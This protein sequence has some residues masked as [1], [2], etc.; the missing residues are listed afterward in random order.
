MECLIKVQGAFFIK[1]FSNPIDLARLKQVL[2]DE[3]LDYFSSI[4]EGAC[5]ATPCN[6]E[7]LSRN[8]FTPCLLML[9]KENQIQIPPNSKNRDSP[10][11]F[12]S[13]MMEDSREIDQTHAWQKREARTACGVLE[14][15]P[16]VANL[17]DI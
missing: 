4:L 9:Q 14:S 6:S 7:N 16:R 11:A 8:P 12:F 17:L 5:K 15:S 13:P 10:F 1:D 3:E 2:V